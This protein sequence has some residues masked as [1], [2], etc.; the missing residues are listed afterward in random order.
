MIILTDE[1]IQELISEQKPLPEGLVPSPKMTTRNQ[2]LRRDIEVTSDA[3][4][5]FIVKLR[6]NEL[7]LFDFSV[8]LGYRLPGLSK[9]FLLRRY[10]GKSH[11][12]TNPIENERFREFHRHTATERYQKR[13]SKEEHFAEIDKRFST[14]DDAI[15]CLLRDCGFMSQ[16]DDLPLFRGQP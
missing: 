3:G 8:I 16:V 5:E 10:N 6:Q 9:I 12:H 1:Q 14:F 15:R 2:S 11:N 4:H 13:G 7:Y